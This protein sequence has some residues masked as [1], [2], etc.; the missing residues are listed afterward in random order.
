MRGPFILHTLEFIQFE[1]ENGPRFVRVGKTRRLFL[2]LQFGPLNLLGNMQSIGD[3]RNGTLNRSRQF[4]STLH[5]LGS[6]SQVSAV[7]SQ[8]RMTSL[9]NNLRN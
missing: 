7:Q 2:A 6:A 5:P 1:Q 3:Y 9:H 8:R 4:R